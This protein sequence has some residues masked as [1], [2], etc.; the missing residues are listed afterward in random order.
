LRETLAAPRRGDPRFA[1]LPSASS[2]VLAL[3]TSG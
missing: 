2:F 3:A 1:T